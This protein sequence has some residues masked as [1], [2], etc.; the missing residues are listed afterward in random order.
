MTLRIVES[1]DDRTE[2]SQGAVR[3]SK[4][5]DDTDDEAE[6]VSSVGTGRRYF[7]FSPSSGSTPT[8][9]Y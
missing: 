6:A 3:K 5:S 2:P 8:H 1:N 7:R 9:G 4:D